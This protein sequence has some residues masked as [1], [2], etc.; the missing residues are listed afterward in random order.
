MGWRIW[1]LMQTFFYHGSTNSTHENM[2][3]AARGAFISLT[4]LGATALIEKMA[5]NQGWS[6]PFILHPNPFHEFWCSC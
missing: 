3:A 2:D 6:K 1:I 5:S 4:I